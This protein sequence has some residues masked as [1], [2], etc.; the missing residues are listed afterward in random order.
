[1]GEAPMPQC[2]G[3]ASQIIRVMQEPTA[4]K[5]VATSRLGAGFTLIELLVVI[6]IITVLVGV[7]LPSLMLA[8]KNAQTIQCAS[9]L[10]QFTTAL[11]NYSIEFRGAFPPNSAQIDQ[12]WFNQAIMGRYLPSPVAMNDGTIAGGAL[13][14]PGDFEGAIRSYSMNIFASS[15]VS[16]GV[17]AD[18]QSATPRGKLFKAG[19]K[20]SSSL[21]LATESFSAFEAPGHEPLTPTTPFA[22]YVPNAIIGFWG[23]RPG[24]KFGTG[25]GAPFVGGRFGDESA[26][27]VCYFRHRNSRTNR[28]ITDAAGRVNIGFLDG[29]VAVFSHDQLAD[30]STGKSRYV[31]LWSPIDRQVD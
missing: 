21:I 17:V 25:A 22:G 10:R 1:M 8:R 24:E 5:H 13:V 28:V 9:N 12:Y 16:S 27:Q 26:C 29:H 15:Y 23:D 11:I 7:L 20:E 4:S 19:A 31:A 2:L 6:G 3:R 18:L 14:C 30:F